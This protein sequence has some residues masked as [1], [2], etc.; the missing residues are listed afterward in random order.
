MVPQTFHVK[1]LFLLLLV[2][3]F[4]S[5]T[6]GQGSIV[7]PQRPY[8]PTFSPDTSVSYVL[9]RQSGYSTLN[10]SEQEM[11]Y[12]VNLLRKD[13]PAFWRNQV[14]HFL[15]TFPEARTAS[16]NSLQHDLLSTSALSPLRVSAALTRTTKDHSA[17]L[18]QKQ[19]ISH[20]GRNGKDFAARMKEAGVVG[21]AGENVFD[22]ENNPLVAL[23]LLLIDEG[24]PS[25][26]HRR[27]LLEPAFNSMGVGVSFR[28]QRSY[29]VQQFGC[30]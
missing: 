21:C 10:Q 7:L 20:R 13:P 15:K 24:V 18:A 6:Q 2:C 8:Q 16:S 25:A 4:L 22:G 26:G 1:H 19:T 30:E 5:T 9:K 3:S 28:D 17:F 29:M 23:I 27:A 11:F 12:W 14:E